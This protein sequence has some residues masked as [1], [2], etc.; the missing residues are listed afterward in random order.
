ME[1]ASKALSIAAGVLIAIL[2][3]ALLIF[4]FYKFTEIPRQREQ[5]KKMQQTVEFNKTFDSFNQ[6]KLAGIKMISLV[7]L[8]N[9]NNTTYA[10][11]EGY[12]VTIDITKD[13]STIRS[14]FQNDFTRPDT[15]LT[16]LRKAVKS[17]T[18]EC[19]EVIYG[20][21]DGRINKMIFEEK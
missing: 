9:D 5:Q 20:G 19:T 15:D 7:N 3:I 17:H 14:D 18:Y 12:Q 13:G 6:R 11:V 4:A 1:N 10:D 8:V 21:T 2:L 16:A